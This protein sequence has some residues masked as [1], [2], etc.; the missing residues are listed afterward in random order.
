VGASVLT[1]VG[2]FPRLD[3]A[4]W[5]ESVPLA[6]IADAVGTPVYVYS[7]AAVRA[8]Y[9]ALDAALEPIPHRIHYSVKAN[10]NLALLQLLRSLGA[11]VDIVSGGELDRARRAGFRGS[12]IIFGGVG[13]TAREL[14]EA[15]DAGVLLINIE[16]EAE[17]ELLS[18]IAARAGVT[19]PVALR[20]NP[21]VTV[22][23]PHPYTRTGERGMRFGIPVDEALAVAQRVRRLPSLRLVGLDAH[24]GSQ[25]AGVE[26]HERATARLVEL[27]QGLRAAGAGGDLRFLDIG[28]G[29]AVSYG[30]TEATDVPTF[31][32]TVVGAVAPTGLTLLV[33]P[34]RY[35]VANAGVLVTRVLYRK[36]SGGKTHV[37]TDAGM[38]DLLR[39]SHYHA[40][41]QIEP[42]SL[43][44][45]Q[46]AR[47]ESVDISGPV[48]ESGDFFALDR[49]IPPVAPGDLLVIHSTGAYGFVMASNYNARPRPPEVL[50]DGSRHAI[51]REREGYDDLVRHEPVDPI[52]TDG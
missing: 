4:L 6:R 43:D 11:G 49:P 18:Q 5:C 33:E 35:L 27:V 31:A 8:Q 16:S 41:H 48:C 24:I 26:P 29:L 46:S 10:G 12:D 14:R 1:T 25:V 21:E 2:A 15:L 40:Y 50:V 20:I 38:T 23:T 17:A 3:G 45:Q 42:V 52:W 36:R 7:A 39:P 44:P 32:R 51:V 34:G 37:I 13:K 19:A 22:D 30:D 9:T 47:P 28:G